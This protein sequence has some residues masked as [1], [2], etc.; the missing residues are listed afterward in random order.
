[1]TYDLR[2]GQDSL[3]S[4]THANFM[5][6]SHEDDEGD[7]Y[8][9][10]FGRIIGVFHAMVQHS[11]PDSSSLE[12]QRMEFLWVRWYGRALEHHGGWKAKHLHQIGFVDS[13]DPAAFGFLDPREVIRGI[14]LIPAFMFG[15]TSKLLSRSPMARDKNEND[16]DWHGYYVSM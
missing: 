4:R 12:P 15:Q 1:M 16:K 13:T 11:G 10:W 14:H 3:N 8:P 7:G 6:L 9:Y 5:T 2:R